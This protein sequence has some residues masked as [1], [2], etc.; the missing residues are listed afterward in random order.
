MTASYL[1][2]VT[3]KKAFFSPSYKFK[4]DGGLPPLSSL[5]LTPKLT[6]HIARAFY[7]IN[8]QRADSAPFYFISF[9]EILPK[10]GGKTPVQIKHSHTNRTLPDTYLACTNKTTPN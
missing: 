1:P 8:A 2:S 5:P 3:K 10:K 4:S 7:P 6:S 9:C